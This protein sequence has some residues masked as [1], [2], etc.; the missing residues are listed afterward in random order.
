MTSA[1]DG[2]AAL[3]AGLRHH[4]IV[5]SALFAAVALRL[6]R[7][8]S[9]NSHRA[10]YSCFLLAVVPFV[11]GRSDIHPRARGPGDCQP[12]SPPP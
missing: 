8:A 9:Y 10:L 6:L 2:Q 3:T 12:H 5:R 11:P 1:H 7:L 4:C